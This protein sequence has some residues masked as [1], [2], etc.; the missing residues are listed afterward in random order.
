MKK[1]IYIAIA[2]MAALT[3]LVACQQEVFPEQESVP[4]GYMRIDFSA[5][6]PDMQKVATRAVEQDGGSV[7]NLTLF[8]FDNYGLFISTE[9]TTAFA[10]E[11]NFKGSFSA[12]VPDN[13]RRI[14]FLA[15][16]N[17]TDF[18]EDDFRNKSESEVMGVLEGSS[19]RMIYW[20]RFAMD[21]SKTTT[22]A[23]QLNANS[24][25]ISAADDA[26]TANIVLLRNHAFITIQNTDDNLEHF[27]T[28]GFVV[29]NSMAY[30]T[31]APYDYDKDGFPSLSDWRDGDYVTLPENRTPLSNITGVNTATKIDGVDVF[32]QY[33]Y[34]CENLLSDPVSVILR[35]HAQ[36]QTAADD[37]Y[38]RV[39][40]Q[41]EKGE[42]IPIRRNHKYILNVDGELK[43]GVK[44]FYE[45][46]DPS[47]PAT[48]NIWASIKEDIDEVAGPVDFNG[49]KSDYVLKVH[50]TAYVLT[51]VDSGTPQLTVYYNLSKRDGTALT[52]EELSIDWED[53]TQDVAGSFHPY[54][55]PDAPV[56]V[57][58][59]YYNGYSIVDLNPMGNKNKREGTLIV[60]FGQLQRPIKIVT[61]KEQEFTPAWVSSQVY[62]SVNAEDKNSRA[63][64]TVM[65]NVPEETPEELF[66]MKVWITV[67]NLD[68]RYGSGLTLPVVKEGDSGYYGEPIGKNPN[69]PVSADNPA[70]GYKYVYEIEKQEDA[71]TQ[72]VYFE[73]ILNEGADAVDYVTIEAPHFKKVTKVVT[74]S[75]EAL[76]SIASDDP[77]MYMFYAAN[78][79][80]DTDITGIEKRP[81]DENIRYFLVPQ[82]INAPVDF[83]MVLKN[84]RGTAAEVYAPNQKTAAD[85]FLFYS[86]NL[87]PNE[88]QDPEHCN[89]RS[90]TN[91]ASL[92]SYWFSID[93][94]YTTG[95]TDVVANSF[96]MQFKTNR[97]KSA[98]V[99]RISSNQHTSDAGLT[100][101]KYAGEVYRSF[102]FELANYRP[103]TFASQVGNSRMPE[104]ATEAIAELDYAAPGERVMVEFDVTSF[105][106]E[107]D[108]AVGGSAPGGVTVNPFGTEFEIY[109]D[110][111]MLAI[112]DNNLPAELKEWKNSEGETVQRLSKGTDGRFVYY[113]AHN[114]TDGRVSLPFMTNSIVSEGEIVIS[115]NQDKVV[116]DTETF[117]ILNNAFE[118]TVMLGN[119]QIDSDGNIVLGAGGEPVIVNKTPVAAG[120]FIAFEM[121]RRNYRIGAMT[122][123]EAGTTDGEGEVTPSKYELR[124]RKE[125][126]FTWQDQIEIYCTVSGVRYSYTCRLDEL[127]DDP[128]IILT[129]PITV[130]D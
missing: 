120:Q 1:T 27:V 68:L 116:F 81:D 21:N 23:E 92:A 129:S 74:F 71:G 8:C 42:L 88:T 65:F 33:I 114:D 98:E 62:G 17:M 55:N 103:F 43:N 18:A 58:G 110:A 19:G 106:S 76:L 54:F 63:H 28:T 20:A 40:I 70:I 12:V 107:S 48:N 53:A 111:P 117:R 44:D 67:N 126:E 13:T 3:G 127:F 84:G 22:F 57:G 93:K 46:L 45:A 89:F 94:T 80:D 91:S 78:D 32:G 119:T 79:L 24:E 73:N 36:G 52:N 9:K 66:P 102:V 99:V 118:G 10:P 101:G 38:Y 16:Q 25:K 77:E 113:V 6:V 82:K 105:T 30:G 61:I 11:T 39:L 29:Y 4:D 100:D 85:E 51:G 95:G 123:V 31:V 26:A 90:V 15:N 56:T 47:T 115:S 72:R 64:V 97:A 130:T 69:L 41:N 60:K 87:T 121:I 109:I 125:Y 124:L 5:G 50:Q 37:L 35:G 122:V 2:M 49:V 7:Q 112:D 75:G 14:H 96:N 128:H 108:E 104:G 83:T 59:E 86:N 34:E